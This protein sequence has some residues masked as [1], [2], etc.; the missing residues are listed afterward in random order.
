MAATALPVSNLQPLVS[1]LAL[2]QG[3]SSAIFGVQNVNR[4]TVQITVAAK[5]TSW[6]SL[7]LTLM[8]SLDGITFFSTGLTL[9][10]DGCI[11]C[12]FRLPF[13]RL[14]ASGVGVGT[15]AYGAF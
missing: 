2:A 13:Y 3:S 6:T 10:A 11:N 5:A 7:T 12:A 14:D 9:T 15:I 1:G 8:G 4:D